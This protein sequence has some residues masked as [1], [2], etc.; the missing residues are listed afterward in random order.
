[1]QAREALPKAGLSQRIQELVLSDAGI[2]ENL[3]KRRRA[4][5]LTRVVVDVHPTTVRMFPLLVAAFLAGSNEPQMLQGTNETRLADRGEAHP[6]ARSRTTSTR[7]RSD[8][9]GRPDA[10][11]SSS[12]NSMRPCA[13]RSAVARER[14]C[15]V[16]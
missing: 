1:M 15:A 8:G 4:K 6:A 3:A 12:A 7:E 13:R 9:T 5:V 2:S 14:P 16:A 11:M 10:R